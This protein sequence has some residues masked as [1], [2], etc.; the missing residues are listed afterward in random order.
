M[1]RPLVSI[2]IADIKNVGAERS[3]STIAGGMFLKEFVGDTPWVHLDIAGTAYLTKGKPY[4]PEGPTGV[5]V[6]TMVRLVV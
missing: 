5:G 2:L 6:A 3:A 1:V 4:R